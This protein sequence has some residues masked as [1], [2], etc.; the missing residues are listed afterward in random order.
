MSRT[1]SRRSRRRHRIADS[2]P[3]SPDT[4]LAAFALRDS[5]QEEDR[6]RLR[7]MLILAAGLHL[8]LFFIHLPTLS[9]GIEV[10]AAEPVYVYP[11]QP[12]PKL[13]IEE[14][15]PVTTE[16]RP[17]LP[18]IPVPEYLVPEIV[19]V[20]ELPPLDLSE[21]LPVT[22]DFDIPSPPPVLA[23][24]VAPSPGPIRVTG[25]VVPPE[26]LFAPRPRYTEPARQ[27]RLEGTVILEAVIDPQGAVTDLKVL[28]P[29]PLGLTQ[30]ALAA[31][32]QW[33]FRPA[34]LRGVPVSVYW[35]LSVTFRLR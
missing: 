21:D 7:T 30:E 15:P 32:R 4:T 9:P 25:E 24:T 3:S 22:A 23:P 13:K 14:P 19:R 26:A 34:A 17:E 29:M 2:R 35:R 20:P 31:A 1:A 6:R 8:L 5:E 12:L 33:R 11:V 16:P 28:K 18:T 27:V 10:E